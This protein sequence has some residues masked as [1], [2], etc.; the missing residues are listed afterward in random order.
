MEHELDKLKRALRDQPQRRE[1]LSRQVALGLSVLAGSSVERGDLASAQTRYSEAL[2]YDPQCLPAVIGLSGAYLRQGKDSYARAQLEEALV[3]FPNDPTVH[4]LMGEVYY[5]Q[6]NVRDAIAEWETSTS[7]KN[8]PRV[9]ARLEKARREFAV[10]ERYARKDT[11]HF[12]FRYEESGQVS[13]SLAASLR[14]FFEEEYG[15]LSD[16]FQFA[17]PAPLVVI[18]YPSREFHALTREPAAVAGLFDGKIRVPVAGVKS[19]TP[20]LRAVMVHELTHAFVHG[21]SGGA[22]P[23]WLQEGLAQLLE[24]KSLSASEE[25]A[26]ARDLAA[27]EGRSWYGELSYA[28]AL[29]FTRYLEKHY[30]FQMFLEA[31]DR[32][33]A[34]KSAEDALKDATLEDFAR[35]QQGWMDDLVSQFAEAP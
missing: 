2:T 35:L 21:K 12:T 33:R 11:A 9:A 15:D 28:S 22:C 19:L 30:P 6:E 20:P 23:R 25:R 17:P 32:M 27:S 16:R 34:G 14:D 3:A 10:D 13:E 4:F 26:L 29:S 8:D 31:L 5:T 18:L 7:L 1:A 24:G